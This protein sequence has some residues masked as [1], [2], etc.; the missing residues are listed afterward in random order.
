MSK[1]I[2]QYGEVQSFSDRKA[3]WILDPKNHEKVAV[4]SEERF[5]SMKQRCTMVR[6]S[7]QQKGG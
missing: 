2:I 7:I 4:I 1:P 6:R 3:Y 5:A